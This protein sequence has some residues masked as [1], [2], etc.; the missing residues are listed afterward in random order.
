MISGKDNVFLMCFSDPNEG[1]A[2]TKYLSEQK[3][4]EKVFIIW[5]SDD[6]SPPASRISLWLRLRIWA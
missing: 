5:K 4:G 6:D 1:T 3:L 2:T